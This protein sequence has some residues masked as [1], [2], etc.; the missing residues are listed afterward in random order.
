MNDKKILLLKRYREL[1]AALDK[2]PN[3]DE[4]IRRHKEAKKAFFRVLHKAK[5]QAESTVG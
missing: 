4:L 5:E 1:S 3:D 2:E